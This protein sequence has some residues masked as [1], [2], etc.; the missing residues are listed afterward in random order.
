MKYNLILLLA[1]LILQTSCNQ[2]PSVKPAENELLSP[3]LLAV[4]ASRGD[5]LANLI[6]LEAGEALGIALSNVINLTGVSCILV[7]GGIANAWDLLQEPVMRSV[8]KNVFKSLLSSVSVCKA[9][10]GEKA[11]FIGAARLAAD[12][13]SKHAKEAL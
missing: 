9:A 10:L 8:E 11:G 2:E 3:Q 4:H 6:F 5:M 1:L 7:G 13:V 12:S